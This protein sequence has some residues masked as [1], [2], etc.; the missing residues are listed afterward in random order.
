MKRE[1]ARERNGLSLWSAWKIIGFL[2]RTLEDGLHFL[3]SWGLLVVKPF[4]HVC[5][6]RL[7]N[8]SE[9]R[10][11][12]SDSCV[13]VQLTLNFLQQ[14]KARVRLFSRWLTQSSTQPPTPPPDTDVYRLM[15]GR[16]IAGEPFTGGQGR[17]SH[18]WLA[19]DLCKHTSDMQSNTNRPLKPEVL[20]S[21]PV[22]R[23]WPTKGFN[24]AARWFFN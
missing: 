18:M 9:H 13:T 22:G 17:E 14:R 19:A 6:R 23:I 4:Q 11:A 3:A 20:N 15:N 7:Q 16:I 2:P 24:A 8:S 10:S 1:R 5:L 21:W 12:A